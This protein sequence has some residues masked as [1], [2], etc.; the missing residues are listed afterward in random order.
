[1]CSTDAFL[2]KFDISLASLTAASGDEQPR[3]CAETGAMNTVSPMDTLLDP[4][5]VY[6]GGESISST[7]PPLTPHQHSPDSPAS[8]YDS[9]AMVMGAIMDASDAQQHTPVAGLQGTASA[10]CNKT[11][12]KDEGEGSARRN[13]DHRSLEH[14]HGS[15]SLSETTESQCQDYRLVSQ[16]TQP[17]RGAKRKSLGDDEYV[18]RPP[19][20][21]KCASKTTKC[22]SK[23]TK[24]APKQRQPAKFPCA[25][26]GCNRSFTRPLDLLRHQLGTKSCTTNGE[27]IPKKYFCGRC[28]RGFHRRDALARH[29]GSKKGCT[30]FLNGKR[31]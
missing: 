10:T 2:D 6:G 12:T 30:K 29:V 23:K 17:T 8:G 20:K 13:C 5:V 16:E 31:R 24:R 1:M 18:E 22:A 26:P 4:S 9:P 7:S 19:K 25:R 3:I 21:I 14:K 15:I 27:A 11:N 28:H